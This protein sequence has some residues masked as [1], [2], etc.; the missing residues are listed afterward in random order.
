MRVQAVYL[1]EDNDGLREDTV[2]SLQ[3]EGLPVQGAATPERFQQ[4]CQQH[5]PDVVIIDRML[6]QGA[7][8]MDAVRWL[9]EQPQGD[10]T[11]V[12]FLTAL[13][14]I[15]DKLDGLG[16]GD[17]YLVKPVD[18]REL[19]A[20]V[21]AIARRLHTA[22]AYDGQDVWCLSPRRLELRSPQGRVTEVSH[23]ECLLLSALAQHHGKLSA[24]GLVE[25]ME[26][27]WAIYEKN[28]LELLLSRL[29]TK[30]RAL[31]PMAINPIKSLRNE[32]YQL[33]ITLTLDGAGAR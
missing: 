6:A 7:D 21:R 4:L 19:S 27:N 30:I 3:A 12:V 33:T 9:R 5:W 28:R 18:M 13:G 17:A 31:Q 32:G 24:K 14:A 22:A 16:L 2:F 11:G 20:V 26:E 15:D 1:L 10:N 8:G 25:A 23:K 29:R